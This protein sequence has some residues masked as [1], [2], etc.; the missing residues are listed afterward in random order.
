M[1]IE[2]KY[3]W[4]RVGFSL[5]TEIADAIDSIPRKDLPNKS[6]LVE[7][8][9]TDWLVKNNYISGSINIQEN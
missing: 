8:L 2:N 7:D 3:K 9:I 4:K 6:K 1:G 5:K